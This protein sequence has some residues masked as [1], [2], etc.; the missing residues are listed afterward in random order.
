VLPFIERGLYVPAR[1]DVIKALL[2]LD[3]RAVDLGRT[4]DGADR[5]LAV[6][7]RDYA[8]LLL[9]VYEGFLAQGSPAA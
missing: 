9:R 4:S 2:D 3:G 5:S 7:Y 1:V 8:A 6:A